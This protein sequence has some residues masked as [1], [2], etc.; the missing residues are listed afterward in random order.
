M[1]LRLQ[2][3]VCTVT[4]HHLIGDGQIYAIELAIMVSV[5]Y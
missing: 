2:S 4:R 5:N 3:T 1:L